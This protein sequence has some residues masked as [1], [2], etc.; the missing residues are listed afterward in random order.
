MQTRGK[1]VY[2]C[3]LRFGANPYPD[4]T[5]FFDADPYPDPDLTLRQQL[6][7]VKS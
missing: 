4:P 6:T 7:D 3:S 1:I 2:A 5:S